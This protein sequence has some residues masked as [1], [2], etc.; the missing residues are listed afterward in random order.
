MILL[1]QEVKACQQWW[2]GMQTHFR[3]TLP[4]HTSLYGPQTPPAHSRLDPSGVPL[5]SLAPR[6]AWGDADVCWA[7]GPLL[8]NDRLQDP[9]LLDGAGVRLASRLCSRQGTTTLNQWTKRWMKVETAWAKH[10]LLKNEAMKAEY[11][12][13]QSCQL[14]VVMEIKWK[15]KDIF[16]VLL[17]LLCNCSL[18]YWFS[19]SFRF[20]LIFWTPQPTGRF[21]S[22]AVLKKQTN[23]LI[24]QTPKLHHLSYPETVKT[25]IIIGFSNLRWSLNE[26]CATNAFVTKN[27]Q[28]LIFYQDHFPLHVTFKVLPNMNYLHS[29]DPVKH[30]LGSSMQLGS[31][32]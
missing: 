15:E 25:E 6:L 22:H 8:L 20:T 18:Q 26:G 3:S 7:P 4:C 12:N 29:P 1:F 17:W 30:I 21:K 13:E 5:P 9:N 2:G 32:I 28:I 10:I 24:T 19:F 23:S 31:L 27:N 14:L 11:K 16:P